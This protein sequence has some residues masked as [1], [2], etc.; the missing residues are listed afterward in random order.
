M[1][2][3]EL[4]NIHH[5]MFFGDASGL[6]HSYTISEITPVRFEFGPVT[7]GVAIRLIVADT[8]VHHSTL[9]RMIADAA[10]KS[11]LLTDIGSF[12]NLS[13]IALAS[14]WAFRMF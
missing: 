8:E 7:T 4:G 14:T 12:M 3:N 10:S 5:E 11:S 1:E 9:I 2:P 6:F 13:M